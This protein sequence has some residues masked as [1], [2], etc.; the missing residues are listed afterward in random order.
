MTSR[1][2]PEI[3][4]EEKYTNARDEFDNLLRTMHVLVDVLGQ[5]RG[6]AIMMMPCNWWQPWQRVAALG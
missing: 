4:L 6:T 1:L 3:L 5:G 2:Y